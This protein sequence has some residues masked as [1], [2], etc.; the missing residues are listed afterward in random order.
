MGTLAMFHGSTAVANIDDLDSTLKAGAVHT[1]EA[2][3]SKLFLKLNQDD[4]AWTFGADNDEVEADDRF[5]VNPFSLRK[6]HVCWADPKLNGGKRE[7]LG[8]V[9]GP[10]SDPPGMPSAD[11]SAKGG[12]WAEQYGFE[13]VGLSDGVEGVEVVYHTNSDGGA[14]AFANLYEAIAGRPSREHCFPIVT[15]GS[16]SYKNRTYGRT[17]HTPRF[18]VV[19]WANMRRELLS[20]AGKEASEAVAATP[21]AD[22]S[23]SKSQENEAPRRRRRRDVA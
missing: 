23:A 12:R 21:E 11:H 5:A 18:E 7:K 22:A 15:L 6:G 19:D 2:G 17:I 4:G 20:G 1:P 8:E 3:G 10:L 13:L 14:K 9:M 16:D